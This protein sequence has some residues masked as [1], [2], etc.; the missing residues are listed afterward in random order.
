MNVKDLTLTALIAALYATLVVVLAPISYG[1]I[2]L[3]AA[4]CLIPLSSLF[5]LPAVV[6]VSIGALVANTY[7]FLSPID[8]VLGAIANLIAAYLIFRLRRRLLL[9]C[10][11]GS[12]VIGGI[13]GGY[14]WL[15]FPPPDI[16]GLTL[17]VWF[18]MIL[19]ITISSLIAI[20]ILGYG[21]V[22]AL[23]ASGLDSLSCKDN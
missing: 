22:K 8:I 21:L 5:G 9:A 14:L 17:P 6:G 11:I 19:S 20:A 3:R 4:D 2:Q 15:F 16:F 13:V 10:V 18:A 1:P 12:C 23:K 7:Y